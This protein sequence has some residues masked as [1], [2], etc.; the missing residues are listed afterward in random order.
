MT[1]ETVTTGVL[2]RRAIL[3]GSGNQALT[4]DLTS[5]RALDVKLTC[6]TADADNGFVQQTFT[7]EVLN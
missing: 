5:D 2:T 1:M 4:I 3:N 6:N 7:L